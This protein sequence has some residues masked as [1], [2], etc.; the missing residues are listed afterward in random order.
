MYQVTCHQL[1]DVCLYLLML[2]VQ[3]DYLPETRQQ[4]PYYDVDDDQLV[5]DPAVMPEEEGKNRNTLRS[6][7]RI[8]LTLACVC[9][10]DSLLVFV[11]LNKVL[12]FS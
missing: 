3:A 10:W 1:S 2:N 5:W 6:L 12:I 7:L 9:F 4:N 8:L 11:C